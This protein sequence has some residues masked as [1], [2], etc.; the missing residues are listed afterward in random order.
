MP[1]TFSAVKRPV[2]GSADAISI[3]PIGN[4][5]VA[6]T[7]AMRNKWGFERI[8]ESTTSPKVHLSLQSE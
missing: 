5:T 8:S 4:E 1:S 2:E 7:N 6:R 3:C